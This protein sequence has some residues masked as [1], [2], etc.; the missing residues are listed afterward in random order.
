MSAEW[1]WNRMDSGG[2]PLTLDLGAGMHT[3]ELH[4]REDGFSLD[5]LLITSDLGYVPG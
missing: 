3:L 2:A 4:N 5:Q 1:T